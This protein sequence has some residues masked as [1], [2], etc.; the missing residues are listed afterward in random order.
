MNGY[1]LIL[2]CL[3]SSSIAEEPTNDVELD[4]VSEGTE[5]LVLE[6]SEP[7]NRRISNEATSFFSKLKSWIFPFGGDSTPTK[8]TDSISLGGRYPLPVYAPPPGQRYKVNCN[9][10]NKEPWVPIATNYGQNPII[11]FVQPSSIGQPYSTIGLLQPPPG[12]QYGA[13]NINVNYGPPKEQYY[14]SNELSANYGVPANSQQINQ[15][16]GPPPPEIYQA[17]SNNLGHLPSQIPVQNLVAPINVNYGP[18]IDV[19]PPKPID[20]FPANFDI[21]L[22]PIPSKPIAVLAPSGNYGPPPNTIPVPISPPNPNYGPPFIGKH[23]PQRPGKSYGPPPRRPNGHGP[24]SYPP[25][26]KDYM[27]PPP[28]GRGQ[29]KHL[30]APPKFI[31]KPNEKARPPH[32]E[33]GPP[34]FIPDMKPP[35]IDSFVTNYGATANHFSTVSTLSLGS[36]DNINVNINPT[37]IAGQ[38]LPPVVPSNSYGTPVTGSDINYGISAVQSGKEYLPPLNSD[39]HISKS[40][41]ISVFDEILE[42]PKAPIPFPNLNLLPLTPLYDAKNFHDNKFNID[43][44]GDS[45]ESRHREV[46]NSNQILNANLNKDVTS[47]DVQHSQQI[48]SSHNGHVSN[49]NGVNSNVRPVYNS[50]INIHY[51]APSIS[52][53]ISSDKQKEIVSDIQI[54]QSVPVAN[55]LSSIEYPVDLIQSPVVDVTASA[56]NADQEVGE[57]KNYASSPFK[58]SDNPIIVESNNYDSHASASAQNITY[59]SHFKRGN[60]L[61]LAIPS[62]RNEVTEA[63]TEVVPKPI[64]INQIL[65]SS[66]NTVVTRDE[67]NKTD[68][69]NYNTNPAKFTL[70]PLDYT[71]WSPSSNVITESMVPPPPGESLWLTPVGNAAEILTTTKKPKQ[72]QIVIPYTNTG[73]TSDKSEVLKGKKTTPYDYVGPKL[74]L[75]TQPPTMESVWLKYT[76]SYR[77]EESNKFSSVV[78]TENPNVINIKDLLKKEEAKKS[79]SNLPFDVISLQKNIDGWTEQEYSRKLNRGLTDFTQISTPSFT[80]PITN[81]STTFLNVTPSPTVKFTNDF[82]DHEPAGSN[83]KESKF[84]EVDF[85][86]NFI[87]TETSTLPTT[88]EEYSTTDSYIFST[89]TKESTTDRSVIW[90]KQ[91]P[92]SDLSKEKIYVITPQPLTKATTVSPVVS[93]SHPPRIGGK[94][95]SE[96]KDEFNE[97]LK[98]IFSEWPHLINNLATT[99]TQR[100]TSPHPLFGLMDLSPYIPPPNSTIQTYAG[101]SKVITIVTPINLISRKVED[102]TSQ[103]PTEPT[104]K[105]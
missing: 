25:I 22:D 48:Y 44:G 88:T 19:I 61:E 32:K 21:P 28:L 72:I 85:E 77:P 90:G 15:N 2:L 27:G 98:L 34:F 45:Q 91:V 26:P 59:E 51:K 82:Y 67:L 7:Y 13:P 79:L 37:A 57:Q 17:P 23:V 11:G 94:S 81:I 40:I 5:K 9:S 60:D 84:N 20:I 58:L 30:S 52:D 8:P 46:Y 102:R 43:I 53:T 12:E 35:Q 64:I 50:A 49:Q 89:D 29:P 71:S 41:P 95:A 74:S 1:T 100:P 66:D 16:L 36:P 68:A 80:E 10:C 4:T 62:F 33:Y 86:T 56:H 78:Y 39:V 69:V 96:V 97:G 73:K 83:N 54:V 38:A 105:T 103:T 93:F 70:P 104:K 65:Q 87:V 31:Q 55:F 47:V 24:L 18:A 6:K 99:T 101:H 76:E 92:L 42:V 3:L 14:A 75:Y 63:A